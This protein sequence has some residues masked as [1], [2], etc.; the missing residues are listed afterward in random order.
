MSTKV[1][2]DCHMAPWHI[3]VIYALISSC[4]LVIAPQIIGPWLFTSLK[5]IDIGSA[6]GLFIGNF[7]GCISMRWF[8][9]K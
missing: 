8:I 5:P 6:V 2:D 9:S 4:A 7:Y 1:E 3:S